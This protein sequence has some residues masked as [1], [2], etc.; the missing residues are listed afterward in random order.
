MRPDAPTGRMTATAGA[1]GHALPAT[2]C[3]PW[4]VAA[5]ALG[6]LSPLAA[7]AG[8]GRRWEQI[9]ADIVLPAAFAI[10]ASKLSHAPG[11]HSIPQS[12]VAADGA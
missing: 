3:Y 5:G 2:P 11:W 8:A 6:V 4:W 10:C 9:P 12:T 1:S 7:V